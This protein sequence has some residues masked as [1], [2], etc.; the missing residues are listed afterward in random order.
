MKARRSLRVDEA[1][2]RALR[3]AFCPPP[4]SA[5]KDA[6]KR[7]VAR[8]LLAARRTDPS[9]PVATVAAA[10]GL[11]VDTVRRYARSYRGMDEAQLRPD[12]FGGLP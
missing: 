7:E 2:L 11:R 10:L 9:I 3:V 8:V 4:P 5:G 6:H 12:L 1:A